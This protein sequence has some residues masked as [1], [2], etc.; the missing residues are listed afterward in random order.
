MSIKEKS[1][2]AFKQLGKGLYNKAELLGLGAG[3]GLGEL[4]LTQKMTES[5]SQQLMPYLHKPETIQQ[6]PSRLEVL[7]ARFYNLGGEIAN[8]L[9]KPISYIT[10]ISRYYIFPERGNPYMFCTGK[11]MTMAF[12]TLSEELS[13][14]SG[15]FKNLPLKAL[16]LPEKVMTELVGKGFDPDGSYWVTEGFDPLGKYT[17]QPLDHWSECLKW[18]AIFLGG[19]I[20]LKYG[21]RLIKRLYKKE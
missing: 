5:L 10:S 17:L 16:G 1:A 2:Y 11:Q 8:L 4:S 9:G 6:L 14:M 3:W 21:P 18:A 13:S 19:V 20:D 15:G 7:G 12:P